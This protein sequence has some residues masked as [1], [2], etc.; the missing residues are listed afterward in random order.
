MS[1]SR[2]DLMMGAGLAGVAASAPA[3]AAQ[4]L[5]SPG[6]DVTDLKAGSM[7]APLGVDDQ[8]VRLSWRLTSPDPDV[9]QTR[10]E[11]Q[12][13]S[14]RERL[15]AGTS[16]LW[17]AGEVLTDQ[18]MDVSWLGGPLTSRQTVWWLSLIHI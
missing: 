14:S 4:A 11:I 15:E 10:Y 7:T 17:N 8:A 12:A 6:L 5:R 13:A 16:D 9:R 1:V 2:R 18:C 3:L